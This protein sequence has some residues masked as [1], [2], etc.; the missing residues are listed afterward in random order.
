M[1]TPVIVTGAA[2]KMGRRITAAVVRDS[3]LE[4]QGA[5]EAPQHPELGTDAGVLAGTGAAGINLTDK[6]ESLIT[7]QSVVIDFTYH[8][9]SVAHVKAC[10][11]QGSAMVIGTTGFSEEEKKVIEDAAL[12]ISV[13]LAPN[14]SLGVNLLFHLIGETARI[15][16]DDFDVEIVE[17]HHRQKKDAPSGTALRLAEIAAAAKGWSPQ[18]TVQ[19]CR[20]GDIGARPLKE[21]GVQ[22]VRGGDIVGEHTVTFAGQGERIEICHRAHSRDTFA[23]GAARA[24]L[25]VAGREPGLYS[26]QDVLG[27][28]T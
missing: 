20:Q 4:L 14:M 28:G 12:K 21:I 7:D 27:I 8:Q 24:A 19:Y 22:S 10:E 25:W 5:T 3:R 16:G 18:D 15:L 23:G 2:G 6:L 17:A 26:M 11:Q 1:K 9:A 13:V